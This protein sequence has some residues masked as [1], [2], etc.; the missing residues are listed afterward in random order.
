MTK[1]KTQATKDTWKD[2]ICFYF[3]MASNEGIHFGPN[4]SIRVFTD[5]RK[6]D[7]TFKVLAK[8]F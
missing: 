7:W 3:L 2:D 1:C 4:Q 6:N 8:W 5:V